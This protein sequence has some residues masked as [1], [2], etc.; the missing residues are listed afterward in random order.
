MIIVQLNTAPACESL[1]T[2]ALLYKVFLTGSGGQDNGNRQN[3]KMEWTSDLG[4]SKKH[5]RPIRW[6]FFFFRVK[7][8]DQL[9]RPVGLFM[10]DKTAVLL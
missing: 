1:F 2:C 9:E 5:E 6:F 10:V 8:R 7:D 3:V 4:R